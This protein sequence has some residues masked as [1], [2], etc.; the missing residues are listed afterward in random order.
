MALQWQLYRRLVVDAVVDVV[1]ANVDARA[2]LAVELSIAHWPEKGIIGEV[3]K[4]E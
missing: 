2:E 1:K 4:K 3:V